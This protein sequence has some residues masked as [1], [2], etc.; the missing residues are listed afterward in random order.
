MNTKDKITTF[1]IAQ[2][3]K[4]KDFFNVFDMAINFKNTANVVV[5]EDANALKLV[6]ENFPVNLEFRLL[7]HADIGDKNT[8]DEITKETARLKTI[9]SDIKAISGCNH[10]EPFFVT[11]SGKIEEQ[12]L[13][14]DKCFVKLNPSGVMCSYTSLWS[15]PKFLEELKTVSKGMPICNDKAK[16][17]IFIG[18]STQGLEYANEIKKYFDK[19][20]LYDAHVWTSEFPDNQITLDC[21]EKALQNFQYSIFVF[22][23]D[24]TIT[25]GKNGSKT[26]KK[27][28][29]DNVIFEYG[30]FYGKYSRTK[31]FLVLP[32]DY[33]TT[34]K[35]MSDIKGLNPHTYTDDSEN[36]LN[37]V[38]TACNSIIE[39][40]K[41]QK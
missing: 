40:I 20:A 28:P 38:T 16:T 30:L 17:K 14:Q 35:T 21:L 5:L 41:K 2:R 39:E 18:S 22:T 23:P 26:E 3:S 33:E 19:N 11:R 1:L 27:I 24:D 7:I 12:C 29:R 4:S 8:D 15:R 9:V 31:T 37:A 10:I 6:L 25:I 32:C 36:K 34:M 13:K